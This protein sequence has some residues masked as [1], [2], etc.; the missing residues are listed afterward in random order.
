M[1]TVLEHGN[2]NAAYTYI[3]TISKYCAT[4]YQAG[5]YAVSVCRFSLLLGHSTLME[6]GS[7]GNSE[8]LTVL[9]HC[10]WGHYI[11]QSWDIT[12]F[13]V[14]SGSMRVHVL[15]L[16]VVCF[17]RP[18]GAFLADDEKLIKYDRHL[19][20]YPACTHSLERKKHIV[21]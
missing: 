18:M 7:L 3:S 5:T 20:F 6:L 17:H 8:L 16:L 19:A 4:I 15:C 11:T 2:P 10:C 21:L 9:L 13:A 12:A 14:R 1:I